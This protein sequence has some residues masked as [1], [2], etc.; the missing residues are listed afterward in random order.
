MISKKTI[1]QVFETVRIEDIVSEKITLN[2]KGANLTGNCPFHEEKT[3]SFTVSPGKGIYKCF[4]CGK[5]GNAVN[6]VM[7]H[8][9]KSYPEAIEYIADYY[10]ILIDKTPPTEKELIEIDKKNDLIIFNNWVTEYYHEQLFLPQNAFVLDYALSRFDMKT[11]IDWQIG[12]A[13]GGYTTLF[14]LARKEKYSNEFLVSSS[15]ATIS[16][17]NGKYYDF[18]QDRLVFPILDLQQNTISFTGRILPWKDNGDFAKFLNL[19]DTL[20]YKKSDV[21]YG[22]NKAVNHINASR[23]A[24]LVEG[25]PDCVKLHQLNI[26]NVVAPCGTSLA[27]GQ[28]KL[29]DR[30]ADRIILLFDG[31]QAGQDALNKYGKQLVNNGLIPYAAILPK[32]QDPD[33]F[34]TSEEHYN[35]WIEEN[36]ID[37]IFWYSNKLFSLINNDPS[38]KNDAIIQVCDMLNNISKSDRQVYIEE[39]ALKSKIKVKLFTDRF[40]ELDALSFIKEEPESDYHDGVDLKELNRWGFYEH[41]NSYYFKT[42]AGKEELSNF[43]MKPIFHID[44]I[45]DSK[46]IYELINKHGF[47]VVVNLD[48]Q[49]MTSLQ[50]FQRN[51]ESKGNFMFWGQMAQFQKLKLKLYEETRTCQEITNLGW[52]KE[53]FWAWANGMV[54]GTGKF[55]PIDEYGVVNHEEQDYFIPAFSKIYLKD[56]SIFIDERKFKFK[57]STTSVNTW[58]DLFLKVHGDN[59]MV[60]FGWYIAALF[61][62]HILYNNDNFPLLNLFGQKGSGKNTL[63]Y[64]LLSLF[65]RKQTEFNIHN[66]TKPGLAKHLEMFRNAI[67]FIDEYKNSLDFDKIETLKSIYNAIGRSRLNMDKGGKKE[68]TEVNQAVIVAGQE[69]PTIDIALS[70]RMI[71]LQFE[72][73]EGL[74]TERKKDFENLQIM[75]RDGLPHITVEILKHRKYFID[76]FKVN[77]DQV[78][79]DLVDSTQNEDLNDRLLRNICTVMASFKTIESKFNFSFNYQQ[80]YEKG[81]SVTIN[82]NRQIKQSDEIGVFWSLL[83]ALFDDNILIDKWHFRIAHPTQ[84]KTTK[85]TLNFGIDGKSILKF[86]YNAVAKMYAEHLRRRGEKPLPQDSLQ[87]YL[88]TNKHFL[89]VEKSCK[90]TRKDFVAAEGK[91]IQQDQTTSAFCFDYEPLGIG[92]VRDNLEPSREDAIKPIAEEDIKIEKPIQTTKAKKDDLPF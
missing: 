62:D 34:F 89:G 20:L 8:D 84:I 59:A 23:S 37:F 35:E 90:F 18:M 11:I 10:K 4:G 75:E 45:N 13:P 87:H 55:H 28:I 61:R 64:S 5:A 36:K 15:L 80:L 66:G 3:P 63:A 21:L 44:T 51:V 38:R 12:Y 57:E 33:S 9:H 71:F 29:L 40:K 76:N 91:S 58:M 60:G 54:N 22:L 85:G 26:T 47:R 27:D 65:G 72:D 82:H 79:R 39:I 42:K 48:M 92:L 49:E 1:A 74:S 43:V 56:K 78:M 30:F 16:Q 88:Q 31:D 68:T 17:K 73:K 81:L 14:D 67:A 41:K 86:K 2:R 46:R 77:Y 69:M 6:F 50:G 53:G 83:E 52:Q 25:N 19:R 24:T 70:S 32:D 7:E